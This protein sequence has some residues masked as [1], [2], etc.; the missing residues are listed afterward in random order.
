MR[1]QFVHINKVSFGFQRYGVFV[2]KGAGTGMG[3][4]IGTTW[5]NARGEKKKT[6]PQSFGKMGTGSRYE[7]NWFNP[8]MEEYIE[9]LADIIVQDY[10]E[11][12]INRIKLIEKVKIK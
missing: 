6:N 3:G 5:Y 11:L 7:K 9:E 12:I 4:S 1:E 8:V 10:P 2:M